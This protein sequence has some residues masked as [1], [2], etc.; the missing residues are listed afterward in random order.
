MCVTLGGRE[1]LASLVQVVGPPGQPLSAQASFEARDAP[2][3]ASGASRGGST[4]TDTA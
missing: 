4:F 1:F 2:A 3:G